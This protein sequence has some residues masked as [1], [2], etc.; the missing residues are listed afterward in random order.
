MLFITKNLKYKINDIQIPMVKDNS[1]IQYGIKKIF[2]GLL[3]R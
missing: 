3:C 1:D 2:G